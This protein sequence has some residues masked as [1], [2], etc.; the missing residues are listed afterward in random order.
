M[1]TDIDIEIIRTCLLIF[2][3]IG[4]FGNVNI[5]CATWKNKTLQHKCGIMLAILACCDSLCLLNEFQSFLRMT[6]KLGGTTLKNCFWANS[7]YVFIEPL[8][9]YMI[10]VLAVD[11]LIALNFVVYY[12]T[13]NRNKYILALV[14]PGILFGL[15]FLIVSMLLLNNLKVEPCILPN[16]MPEN[17]SSFWNQYNLWGAIVTI[18][19]YVYTYLVV[20][21]CAFKNK[22]EKNIMIQKAI[23]NT[24]IVGAA[25]FSISSV[26][27]A[28]LIAITSNMKNPP[29]DPDTV[30]TYAV[31]PGLVSYSCNFYV[32]YWRSTDYRNA[33]IKQL[34]CGKVLTTQEAVVSTMSVSNTT[35]SKRATLL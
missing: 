14:T 28:S 24:V 19:V 22:T 29:L 34:C 26:L 35:F 4:I 18:V 16:A 25:V 27:S 2:A 13:V 6:L 1:T 33:F 15:A 23:L 9:V 7:S 30:A 21:C 17:V 3:V 12:R 10:F 31:I 8:E 20:Y 11:R 5:I 32:Y